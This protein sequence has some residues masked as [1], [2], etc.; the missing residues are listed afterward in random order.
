MR[1]S[2]MKTQ[3]LVQQIRSAVKNFKYGLNKYKFKWDINVIMKQNT[4]IYPWNM[5]GAKSYSTGKH[6]IDGT[7][8][9]VPTLFVQLYIVYRIEENTTM[10]FIYAFLPSKQSSIYERLLR[11]LKK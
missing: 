5:Q 8:E 6:L 11:S 10:P 2:M 9:R 3:Q 7:F 1:S 4:P